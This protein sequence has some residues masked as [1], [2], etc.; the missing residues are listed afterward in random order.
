MACVVSRSFSSPSKPDRS[1]N[2]TP[3]PLMMSC[4]W[5]APFFHSIWMKGE[6]S[7]R[8]AGSANKVIVTRCVQFRQCI[9]NVQDAPSKSVDRPDHQ[10]VEPTS[11]GIFQHLIESW[12]LISALGPADALIFI[13]LNLVPTPVLSHS[14]QD[15]PLILS[16][17]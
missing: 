9:R 13:A 15:K 11:H 12:P 10:N 8:P 5:A 6:T 16:G 14:C 7:S 2:G 3:V 4:S 1:R 17:L